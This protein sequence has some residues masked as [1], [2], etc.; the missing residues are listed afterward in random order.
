VPFPEQRELVRDLVLNDHVAIQ[1][2]SLS[3]AIYFSSRIAPDE[4]CIFEVIHDFG[5]D[6]VSKEHAMFQ[7]QFGPTRNFPL[8]AGDFLHLFLTNAPEALYAI[9]NGWPEVH[10]LCEAMRS[11]QYEVVYLRPNDP[12][13]DKVLDALK[14]SA[15]V[16]QLAAVAA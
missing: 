16:L 15:S 5:F 14:I 6:E 10:D 8:P 1:S 12:D 4:E 3:L 7:V 13:A 11:G 2:V 9:D